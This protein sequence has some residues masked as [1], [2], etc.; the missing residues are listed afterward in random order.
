MSTKKRDAGP[1]RD[2]VTLGPPLEDDARFCDILLEDFVTPYLG[3][4]DAFANPDC[5]AKTFTPY[6]SDMPKF[7]WPAVPT[8]LVFWPESGYSQ[9][10]LCA[11]STAFVPGT[12]HGTGLRVNPDATRSRK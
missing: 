4:E 3:Q 1:C 6:A 2:T 8:G 11:G 10:S 9:Q 5:P 7:K 12:D